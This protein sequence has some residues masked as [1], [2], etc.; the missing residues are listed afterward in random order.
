MRRN[1]SD[2]SLWGMLEEDTARCVGKK[3]SPEVRAS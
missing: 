2:I 3:S 1:G